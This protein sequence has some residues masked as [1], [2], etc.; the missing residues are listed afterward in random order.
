MWSIT[1]SIEV[2][3]AIRGY[4]N[5]AKRIEKILKLD[6]KIE[7]YQ[8][9]RNFLSN[10]IRENTQGIIICSPNFTHKKYIEKSL[11]Y[12]PDIPIYCEK[13]IFNHN[14]DFSDIVKFIKTGKIFPGFNLRRSQVK[15]FFYNYK[16]KL[17]N[18]KSLSI[19]VSYPFGLKESYL[20]SWKSN[21][22][23][24][25]LGV[26]ENLSV[27]FVDLA[28]YLFGEEEQRKILLSDFLDSVPRNCDALIK[29][30]N[31]SITSIHNSYSEVLNSQLILNFDNGKIVIDDHGTSIYSP[32]LHLDIDK[33]F[34]LESPLI[35]K[36]KK[37]FGEIFSDSLKNSVELFIENIK[38]GKTVNIDDSYATT[39][40]TIKAMRD[41]FNENI[42]NS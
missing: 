3:I 21:Y 39:F 16:K 27:H 25:S 1:P 30:K 18:T 4:G 31:G 26:M 42:L 9:T 40:L 6:K 8:I 19:R 17:G 23:L 12:N 14:K 32:T 33:D 13:P 7:T 11:N 41:I 29:H 10:E 38:K 34:C 5:H 20:N 22:E 37:N 15:D 28:Y 35:A 24:S 36:F 2:K